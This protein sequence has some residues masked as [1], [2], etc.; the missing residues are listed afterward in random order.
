[1]PHIRWAFRLAKWQP[2][3]EQIRQAFARIQSEEIDRLMKFVFLDDLKA[4]LV[5]RLMIR[6]FVTNATGLSNPEILIQ[7]DERGKP[8]YVPRGQGHRLD[9]NVSHQGGFSVLAGFKGEGNVRL[10]VD[11]MK[12]EYTGGKS[13]AE[14]FRLMDRN[15]TEEEWRFIKS[16]K[17]RKELISRF[18]RVWCLKESY[19][20]TLGV[21]IT[22]DLRKINFKISTSLVDTPNSLIS[23]TKVALNGQSEVEQHWRFEETLLDYEHCVAVAVN[24]ERP[25]EEEEVQGEGFRFIDFEWL[26]ENVDPLRDEAEI[27]E[28][29]CTRVL[30]KDAKET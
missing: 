13:V 9:F 23:S 15:F 20:K 12:M 16:G 6:K 11:V 27:G 14:F 24:Q 28:E 19:V 17:D 25:E 10:G 21:G 1:M 30:A 7:R 26:I 8:F 2:S 3:K 4:S 29:L 22:V 18:M 5:G